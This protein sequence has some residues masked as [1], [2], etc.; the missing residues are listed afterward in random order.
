MEAADMAAEAETGAVEVAV[1]FVATTA[2]CSIYIY[3][4]TYIHI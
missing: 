3:I 2:V 1:F 4:Y